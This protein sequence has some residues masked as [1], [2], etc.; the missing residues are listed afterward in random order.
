L[1]EVAGMHV[2]IKLLVCMCRWKLALDSIAQM[3]A[4][5]PALNI[6]SH[7]ALDDARMLEAL[8]FAGMGYFD[9]AEGQ[10]RDIA[11][12]LLQVKVRGGS[13]SGGDRGEASASASHTAIST[14]A[15]GHE[16]D[17]YFMC[18]KA[19]GRL[20]EVM[21]DFVGASGDYMD[22]AQSWMLSNDPVSRYHPFVA[23]ASFCAAVARYRGGLSDAGELETSLNRLTK[24]L[25]AQHPV[26]SDAQIDVSE[27]LIAL[28]KTD[29]AETLLLEAR[30][31]LKIACGENH[32]S[33]ARCIFLLASVYEQRG[34]AGRRYGDVIKMLDTALAVILRATTR[35]HVALFPILAVYANVC[36]KRGSGLLD[37]EVL[38]RRWALRVLGATHSAGS[39]LVDAFR[40]LLVECLKQNNKISEARRGEA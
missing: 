11:Q 23:E 17:R 14:W 7:A 3:T 4:S 5:L 25:G 29:E 31:A 6:K 32:P 27:M 20:R 34:P 1:V 33:M 30:N 39:L 2:Q 12:H 35:R 40:T 10:L 19:A 13:G 15:I 8:C 36:S 26:V 21:N 24:A 16:R 38:L 22:C 9:Q 37:Q 18:V 28:H